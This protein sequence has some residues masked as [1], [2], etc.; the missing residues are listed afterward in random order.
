MGMIKLYIEINNDKAKFGM[1]VADEYKEL[2]GDD[3]S[4]EYDCD[5][6]W[7]GDTLILSIDGEPLNCNFNKSDNTIVIPADS[8]LEMGEELVFT[9][10]E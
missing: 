6:E 10:I 2:V 5:A 3:M 8:A 4:E 1:N 9:K 7:D